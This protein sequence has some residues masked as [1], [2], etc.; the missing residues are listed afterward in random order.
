MQA[1]RWHPSQ[2][3]R[4]LGNEEIT[5]VHPGSTDKE[6]HH[7]QHWHALANFRYLPTP[8]KARATK[9]LPSSL[10]FMEC[11]LGIRHCPGCFI[12]WIFIKT[13]WGYHFISK[14]AQTRL[15]YRDYSGWASPRQNC[16]ASSV[17]LWPLPAGVCFNQTDCKH[18]DRKD[19]G[20][21]TRRS[22]LSIRRNMLFPK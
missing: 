20:P 4:H 13:L 22:T 11:L 6:N 8:A 19:Y 3:G 15:V 2:R 9:T 5:Q 7:T 1:V 10:K 14:Q 17:C 21:R 12:R 18:L 16:E